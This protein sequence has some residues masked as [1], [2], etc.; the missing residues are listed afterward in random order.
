VK[1]AYEEEVD[2]ARGRLEI[3]RYWVS[4]ALCTLP[5]TELCKELRSIAM[6]ER[7]CLE[8]DTRSSERRYF[9]ASTPADAKQFA[10]AVR[11]HWGIE[12]RLHWQLD[13]VF[14]DNASRVRKG[15]APAIITSIRHL[16]LNLFQREPSALS[17]AKKRRKTA[18]NDDYRAK[19]LFV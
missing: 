11:G 16:C 3:R 14:G 2:K 13:V 4:E 15:N 17:L 7:E 5:R 19:V 1:Y 8:G 18:W 12:N 9:I 10:H 6:V